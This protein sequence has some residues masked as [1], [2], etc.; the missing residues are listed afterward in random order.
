MLN[1]FRVKFPAHLRVWIGVRE[2]CE[3]FSSSVISCF[4]EDVLLAS[5]H[6]F[7]RDGLSFNSAVF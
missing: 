5:L 1:N 7:P 6:R 3:V 4:Q 2:E